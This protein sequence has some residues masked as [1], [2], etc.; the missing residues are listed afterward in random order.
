MLLR[1][2]PPTLRTADRRGAILIVVI[3]LLTIFAVIAITFVFYSAAEADA[4]RIH[5]DGVALGDVG[6]PDPN[7]AVN[8][9]L[10]ALIYPTD[11]TNS[12]NLTNSLRGHDLARGMYGWTGTIGQNPTPFNGVGTFHETTAL[13]TAPDRAKVVSYTAMNISGTTYLY[14]PEWTGIRPLTTSPPYPASVPA[15][16]VNWMPMLGAS[17]GRTYVAKNAPYTYPDANNLFLASISPQTG[18]VLVP[19]YYRTWQFRNASQVAVLPNATGLEPPT[20]LPAG[21]GNPNW[22]TADGRA[23]ILR[24]RPID[25]TYNGTTEFPYVPAN[26]DGTFTGDVQN[27]SGGYFFDGTNFQARNDSLW[28]NVGLAPRKWNGKWVI[29][30]IAPIVLDLDGRVNLS[31]HGN[32]PV[33]GG[34]AGA[35]VSHAG[36]GPWE[37]NPSFLLNTENAAVVNARN[38]NGNPA[39]RSNLLARLYNNGKRLP[40][41]SQVN[42]SGTGGGAIQPPTAA[43]GTFTTSP[44]YGA[45][46]DDDVTNAASYQT[47]HPSLFNPAEWGAAAGS[48]RTFAASDLRY[49]SGKYAADREFYQQADIAKLTAPLA[50]PDI[51]LIRGTPSTYFYDG[52]T[53]SG[54]FGRSTYRLD[55]VHR[56]RHS[57]TTFGATLDVPGNMTS[58]NSAY[59]SLAAGMRFA[60]STPGSYTGAAS[61]G[62][63]ITPVDL[64]RPLADFRNDMTGPLSNTTVNAT[65]AAAAMAD[66]QLLARDIFVRLCIATGGTFTVNGN[67]YTN[68][69]STPPGVLTIYTATAAPYQSGDVEISAG[70]TATQLSALRSL[71]QLAANI[72]DYLDNDDVSTTFVWKP[73]TPGLSSTVV[74]DGANY[75]TAEMPNRVVIGVEK[76]RLVI[77]ESYSE[78]ANQW[79]EVTTEVNPPSRPA[80][81]RFWV[82]LLNPS[83]TPYLGGTDNPLGTGSVQL[84][85]ASYSPYRIQIFQDSTGTV[86]T[87]LQQQANV[88]GTVA[89]P[90][91]AQYDFSA[92]AG[93]AQSTVVAPNSGNYGNGPTYLNQTNGVVLVGPRIDTYVGRTGPEP[94]EFNPAS[95]GA[96]WTTMIQS[97]LQ[98]AA[99]PTAPAMEY[100]LTTIPDEATLGGPNYKRHVIVLQRLANPY[101]T[102]SATN[103]YITVDYMDYVPSFDA[104]LR[105]PANTMT[106]RSPKGGTPPTGAG[107]DPAGYRFSIGKVQPYAGSAY[108][109]PVGAMN[110]N[111]LQRS[112]YNFNNAA[113]TPRS[114]VLAQNPT[115]FTQ[116]TSTVPATSFGRHNGRSLT[117]GLYT[118]VGAGLPN[119]T[120]ETLMT[121]FD[122]YVHMDRPL[123][124]PMELLHVAAV[125]P[126]AL[127]QDFVRE[128]PVSSAS[129]TRKDMALAAWLGTDTTGNLPGYDTGNNRTNNQLYRALDL[130][131]VRP[132]T[133]GAAMGGKV[134]GRVNINTVQDPRV[135]M[136]LLDPQAGNGFDANFVNTTA[137]NSWIG[138]RTPLSS[139]QAVDPTQPSGTIGVS[140]P[141]PSPLGTLDENPAGGGTD[142]PFKPFGVG[143]L[144][145]GLSS[146]SGLQDTLLRGGATPLLWNTTQPHPYQQA[147]ALRKALNNTTTMSNS[148]VVVFTVGYFE[149]RVDANGNP[150][151]AVEGNHFVTQPTAPPPAPQPATQEVR[152]YLLGKEAYHTVPGD[153]RQQFVAVVDRSNLAMHATTQTGSTRPFHTAL[154]APVAIGGT[155]ILIAASPGSSD[156]ASG[157]V[158]DCVVYADGVAMQILPSSGS[159]TSYLVIG[160]G[161]EQ[162][163]LQIAMPSGSAPNPIEKVS[164]G[165]YRIYLETQASPPLPSAPLA[166]PSRGYP[167]GTLVSNVRYGNPGPQGVSFDVTDPKNTLYR[168]VVPYWARTR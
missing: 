56:N 133:A 7:E 6:Q 104:V 164:T 87:S 92:Q 147:E 94:H 37:V 137:W 60:S 138:S 10:G 27:L 157:P 8:G 62:I 45:G 113:G 29:P 166:L 54:S 82:E 118:T 165:Q 107:Y 67:T 106:A 30:L 100:V 154:E 120:T 81:V 103:P 48:R 101:L 86:S 4:A 109:T 44:T 28:M 3:A 85:Y 32:R 152:R 142:R 151:Y 36:Y 24:P 121:P 51:S 58:S 143:E 89:T 167:V 23:F 114:Y 65:S 119:T 77:N 35:H 125:K 31:A 84:R 75:T 97:P 108:A 91:N 46:Y 72:V 25:N 66:R 22:T 122:W 1:T 112:A 139:V 127:T 15:N 136:A 73:I 13:P 26:A 131:R 148:F 79:D 149:A 55:P 19:S 42:W 156:P 52:S 88:T 155:S 134:H 144:N 2:L 76:P 123:A 153:L 57:V 150:V 141:V 102:P 93:A 53:A 68:T 71:A 17:A 12:A 33:G 39:M 115:G 159:Y 78:I 160:T 5:R 61:S 69:L 47:G 70:A 9:F 145:A 11:D 140:V 74:A 99:V 168:H 161:A 43:T 146:A 124:N 80:H 96:P 16:T 18:Q 117:G 14:D 40:A 95:T 59:P 90:P 130:L 63:A 110:T 163:V 132:W 162:Q 98:G 116:A 20:L 129:A 128:Y 38:N 105:T 49:L 64:N 111:T 41:Y 50:T 126:T 158:S 135:L 83:S 21:A 34:N